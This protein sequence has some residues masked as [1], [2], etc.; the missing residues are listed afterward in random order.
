MPGALKNHRGFDV[1]IS[2]I[3]DLY[4]ELCMGPSND[5]LVLKLNYSW[6]YKKKFYAMKISIFNIFVVLHC[7]IGEWTMTIFSNKIGIL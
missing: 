2:G 5:H 3:S 1:T 4:R 6:S 7:S